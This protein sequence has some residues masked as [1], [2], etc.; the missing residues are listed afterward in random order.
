MGDMSYS[1]GQKSTGYFCA[2]FIEDYLHLATVN[3]THYSFTGAEA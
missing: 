1:H 2:D 3:I